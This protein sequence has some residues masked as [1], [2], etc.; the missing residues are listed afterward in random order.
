MFGLFGGLF[1]KGVKDWKVARGW[2]GCKE[3]TRNE[4]GGGERYVSGKV[5]PSG[6]RIRYE[7]Q[8]SVY[9][10]HVHSTYA[11]NPIMT[12]AY[13]RGEAASNLHQRG[14]EWM[15]RYLP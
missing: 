5:S 3:P 14:L 8:V 4:L 2:R 15:N 1:C 12:R 11:K 7:D 6:I 13:G 10:V 9:Q